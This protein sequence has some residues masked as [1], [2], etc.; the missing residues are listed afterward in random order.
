MS[1]E[2]AIDYYGMLA[3]Q[4]DIEAA[5]FSNVPKYSAAL[6]ETADKYDQ[7]YKWLCELREYKRGCK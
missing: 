3:R 6:R 2:E 1:L 5:Y 4:A 7:L